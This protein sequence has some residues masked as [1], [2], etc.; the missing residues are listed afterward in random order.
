MSAATEVT[1]AKFLEIRDEIAR[2]IR[3]NSTTTKG[4][5]I[6]EQLMSA[7]YID[8]DAVIAK[9]TPPPAAPTE[10]GDAE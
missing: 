1:V 10:D 2:V 8:V 3:R 5:E 6:A 9:I 4:T 7:G